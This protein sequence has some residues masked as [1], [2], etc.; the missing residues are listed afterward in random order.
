MPDYKA[1]FSLT[2]PLTLNFTDRYGEPIG[3]LKIKPSTLQWLGAGQK[4]KRSVPLDRLIEWI[5]SPAAR[6]SLVKY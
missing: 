1:Q 2:S 5:E 3:S 4:K 6:A